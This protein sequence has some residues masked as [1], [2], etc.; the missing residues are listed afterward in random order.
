MWYAQSKVASITCL[1][2]LEHYIKHSHLHWDTCGS[3][4]KHIIHLPLHWLQC[5]KVVCS[6]QGG[7]HNLFASAW[8]LYQAQP[9]ALG[10]MWQHSETHHPPPP[11]LAAM[12]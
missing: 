6:E 11:A 1:P 12:P 2:L 5:H 8:A 7:I 4:V 10:H 3:T 9:L